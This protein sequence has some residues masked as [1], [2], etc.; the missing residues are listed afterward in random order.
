MCRMGRL[1][2]SAAAGIMLLQDTG[3]A[4]TSVEAWPQAWWALSP[5]PIGWDVLSDISLTCAIPIIGLS[6]TWRG[7]NTYLEIRVGI[8]HLSKGIWRI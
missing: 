8:Y 1:L 3:L 7:L 6:V 4:L 5:D 2:R